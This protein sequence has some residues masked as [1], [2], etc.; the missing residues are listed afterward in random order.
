MISFNKPVGLTT[1]NKSVTVRR[2]YSIVFYF[3]CD[4]LA[5]SCRSFMY[6]MKYLD[7]VFKKWYQVD[8][9]LA[10]PRIN[11]SSLSMNQQLTKLI[12]IT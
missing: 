4:L 12:L 9:I 7:V 1:C 5:R 8:F 6:E 2:V 10:F 11:C 3:S